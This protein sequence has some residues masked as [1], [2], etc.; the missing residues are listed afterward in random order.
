MHAKPTYNKFMP[1]KFLIAALILLAMSLLPEG[2]RVL[3]QAPTPQA[4]TPAPTPAP[5]PPPSQVTVTNRFLFDSSTL[6]SAVERSIAKQLE[7]SQSAIAS[8]LARGQ[9]LLQSVSGENAILVDYTDIAKKYF[10]IA[11]AI[12]PLFFVLRLV[13]YQWNRLGGEDDSIATVG[14]DY[15]TAIAFALLIGPTA[16][17]IHRFIYWA[18]GTFGLQALATD[19]ASTFSGDFWTT[20][21][22]SLSNGLFAVVV[23]FG[24][25][26]AAMIAFAAFLVGFLSAFVILYIVSAIGPIVSIV[27][28]IPQLRWVRSALIKTTALILL[29][30]LLGILVIRAIA[31]LPQGLGGGIFGALVRTIF[32]L[33]AASVMLSAAG[34]IGKF[35]WGSV[36]AGAART[37]KA[38][39]V[40]AATALSGGS[41]AGLAATT[42]TTASATSSTTSFAASTASAPAAAAATATSPAP[43]FPPYPTG[44]QRQQLVT[45]ALGQLAGIPPS[46]FSHL[47]QSL[48]PIRQYARN[49]A[50]Q[51]KLE[52]GGEEA[53]AGLLERAPDPN[54]HPA[55]AQ[56]FVRFYEHAQQNHTLKAFLEGVREYPYHFQDLFLTHPTTPVD[57]VIRTISKDHPLYPIFYLPDQNEP[58]EPPPYHIHNA[59][60]PPPNEV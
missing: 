17:L 58:P 48:P 37:L 21:G 10:P 8:E 6:S 28:C 33:G 24:L 19:V 43:S 50:A 4:P 7:K 11:A 25:A 31:I 26:V 3:A 59:P 45:T 54:Q 40:I 55:L 9:Q 2:G 13:I 23:G 22:N 15:L 34:L 52:R 46:S 27:A 36:A 29:L 38:A 44:W 30:P 57:E 16:N 14:M 35:T 39:G 1:K 32:M 49:I 20:F 53:L 47:S 12:A 18:V 51:F 5:N 56:N 60:P 42:T 41:A